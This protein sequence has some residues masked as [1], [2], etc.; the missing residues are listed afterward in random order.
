MGWGGNSD[1]ELELRFIIHTINYSADDHSEM[2]QSLEI[3]EC[4]S[5]DRQ[6]QVVLV[7]HTSIQSSR[8]I[9]DCVEDHLGEPRPRK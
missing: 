4:A 3:Q 8:K 9:G 2:N 7:Y 6:P 5:G 1:F